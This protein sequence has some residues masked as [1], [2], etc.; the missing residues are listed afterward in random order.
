MAIYNGHISSG[1]TDSGGVFSGGGFGFGIY[2]PGNTSYN[3]RVKNVS[4]VG[5]LEHG[6]ALGLGLN[7]STVVDSCTVDV[8]GGIGIEAE[9]VSDSTAVVWRYRHRCQHG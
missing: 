2:S 1:V 9:L 3:V 8:S 7:D 4:V 6:I 5:V